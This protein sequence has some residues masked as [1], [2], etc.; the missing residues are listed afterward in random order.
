MLDTWEMRVDFSDYCIAR[1]RMRSA[2]GQLMSDDMMFE[3]FEDF[4]LYH[5]WY[6]N[7]DI[8]AK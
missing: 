7:K 8:E 1:F 2:I 5:N 3:D 4:L 6:L